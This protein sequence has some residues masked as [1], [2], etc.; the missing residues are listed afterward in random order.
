MHVNSSSPL[1]IQILQCGMNLLVPCWRQYVDSNDIY[2][3]QKY[4]ALPLFESCASKHWS[5]WRPQYTPNV[6]RNKKVFLWVYGQ[7]LA[8]NITL[9]VKHILKLHRRC[10]GFFLIRSTELFERKCFWI[11]ICTSAHYTQEGSEILRYGIFFHALFTSETM[12]NLSFCMLLS[13]NS[14][15]AHAYSSSSWKICILH[16]PCISYFR[17][18]WCGRLASVPYKEMKQ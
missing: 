18:K 10:L 8:K 9:L 4:G 3:E 14:G 1:E 13:S 17:P 7:F 16:Y 12:I 2:F 5:L 6:L 11:H 15:H